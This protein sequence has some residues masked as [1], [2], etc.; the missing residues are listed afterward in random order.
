MRVANVI[1][2]YTKTDRT[3]APPGSKV[4]VGEGD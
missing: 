4:N 3:Q 1:R 2:D